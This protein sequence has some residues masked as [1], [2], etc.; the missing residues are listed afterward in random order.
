[1]KKTIALIAITSLLLVSCK[2]EAT[3]ETTTPESQSHT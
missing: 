1:M 2:K 3:T